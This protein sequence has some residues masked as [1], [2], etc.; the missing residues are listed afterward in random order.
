M[1]ISDFEN[2]WMQKI[3]GDLLK[4]FPDYFLETENFEI[5]DLP[6]KPLLKGTELFG[7]YE[8]VDTD[9]TTFLSSNNLD[10]VKFILYTNHNRPNKT[11]LPKDSAEIKSV[12][13]KYE[14][15]L[16]EILKMIINEFKSKFPDSDKYV[17]VSSRIFQLLN[18]QRF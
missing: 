16:D 3:K 1:S 5:L 14:K 17:S 9:G 12:V 15:H 18:L 13:K 11:K 6:G 8:I 7:T 10:K 4:N 2:T